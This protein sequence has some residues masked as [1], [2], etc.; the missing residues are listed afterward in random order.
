VADDRLPV[1]DGVVPQNLDDRI[2]AIGGQQVG[3]VQHLRPRTDVDV[4][5]PQACGDTV[6]GGVNVAGVEA[7]RGGDNG[8]DK[9]AR[10]VYIDKLTVDERVANQPETP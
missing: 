8:G 4:F 1:F 3:A 5:V 6:T 7:A 2:R 9:P 10:S